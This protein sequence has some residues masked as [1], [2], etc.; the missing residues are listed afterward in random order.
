M[1]NKIRRSLKAVGTISSQLSSRN[2]ELIQTSGSFLSQRNEAEKLRGE[3]FGPNGAVVSESL[4]T[5]AL[6]RCRDLMELA[7]R[8]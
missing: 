2:W 8:L 3:R 6:S 7:E 4:I 5:E 1:Q